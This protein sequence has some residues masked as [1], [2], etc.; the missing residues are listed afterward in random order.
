M[1]EEKLKQKT[2]AIITALVGLTVVIGTLQGIELDQKE[3]VLTLEASAT[4]VITLYFQ[5][6]SKFTRMASKL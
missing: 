3:L 6:K 4:A 5:F 1:T 2:R